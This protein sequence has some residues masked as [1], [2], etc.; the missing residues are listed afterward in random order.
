MKALSRVDEGKDV[1]IYC[2]KCG[3][4]LKKRLCDLGLFDG[5]IINIIKN[6]KS[7]PLVIKVKDSKIVVGRGQAEQINVEEI[8]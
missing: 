2:V 6:D 1:E 3:H 5:T 8:S 7:G 4:R